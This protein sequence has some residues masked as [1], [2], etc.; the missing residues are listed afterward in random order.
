VRSRR[1]STD[2]AKLG[3]GNDLF[4]WNPGDGNDTV[5]GQAG[6]DRLAFNGAN[7]AE[8][9]VLSANGTHAVLTRDIAG[10][11][12]D[13]NNVETVDIRAL[14]GADTITVNDLAKTAVKKVD[15]ELGAAGG[16]G[17]GA[18]DTIVINATEADDGI[19]VANNNGVVTV[20]GLAADIDIS[21]F[22]ANDRLVING[23]GGDDVNTASGL[24]GIQFTAD[25][26]NG[27]DVLVG[28]PGNDTLLGGAGDD[29]LVGNGGQDVLD[30]GTSANVV[31]NA[32]VQ[33]PGGNLALLAQFAASNFAPSAA[34]N[35]AMPPADQ[36][37]Q[38]PQLAMPH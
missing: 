14:G 20:T 36:A 16:V 22:E 18:V 11:T 33:A 34:G 23:L 19:T 29:V 1:I 28:S 15:I 31:F 38:A 13:L 5:D 24:S 9:M 30:G 27:A 4:V 26:G 12:M 10:I 2:I 32:P 21:H 3:A 7:V 25:G 35:A 37:S 6:N 17:D 8:D